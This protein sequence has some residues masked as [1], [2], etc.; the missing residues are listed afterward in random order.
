MLLGLFTRLGLADFSA[1]VGEALSC[2]G[3]TR[4]ELHAGVPVSRNP[5][6]RMA[7]QMMGRIPVIWGAGLLAPV[8]RRWKTQINENA[9]VPAYWEELPELN[10][11][12]VVGTEVP[13]RALEQIIIVQLVSRQ[14]DHPRVR[15]RQRVTAGLLLQQA[16]FHDR[17][18]AAGT[19]RLAQQLSLLQ[20]GDYTSYYLAMGYGMDPTPI[21]QIDMLK[22]AL[23]AVENSRP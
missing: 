22:A 12:T 15:T 16:I 14:Y 9:K 20:Y 6:K 13:R 2:L 7:G 8:A 3:Q 1:E 5:A 19:S 4:D 10:H 23:S 18:R 17:V 11:N 21:P